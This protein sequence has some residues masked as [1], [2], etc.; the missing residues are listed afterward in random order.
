MNHATVVPI[1][2]VRFALAAIV[3]AAALYSAAPAGAGASSIT[4]RTPQGGS[5]LAPQALGTTLHRAT[6]VVT[7]GSGRPTQSFCIEFSE[8]SISG[9][10]LL[11]RSGLPLVVSNASSSLGAAVCAIDGVGSTDPSTYSTCFGQY[12]DYWAYYQYLSGAWRMS[13]LGA[14]TSRV[15]DG[16]MEG[17]AWGANARPDS[18]I[19]VCPAPTPTAAATTTALAPTTT[20]SPSASQVVPSPAPSATAAPAGADVAS[21]LT[22]D[23]APAG[24]AGPLEMDASATTPTAPPISEVAAGERAPTA[25]PDRDLTAAPGETVTAPSGTLISPEQGQTNIIKS[26]SRHNASR[27]SGALVGLVVFGCIAVALVALAALRLRSRV[28]HD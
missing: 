21:T 16:S 19:G 4:T 22:P 25:S 24:T 7:F 2:A 6:L 12:P 15:Q 5:C 1:R 8:D 20:A 14:S 26:Q 13:P 10:E 11:Q 27:T 23:V 9:L 3:F 17:W 28:R 18:P